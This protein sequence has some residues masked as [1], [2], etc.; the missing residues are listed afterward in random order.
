MSAHG[1]ICHVGLEGHLVP[2]TGG[3]AVPTFSADRLRPFV[4][5]EGTTPTAPRNQRN[6][7]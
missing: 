6:M 5:V 2:G 1:L 7:Y 3:A 4:V